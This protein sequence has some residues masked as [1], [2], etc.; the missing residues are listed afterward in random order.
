MS[1]ISEVVLNPETSQRISEH[2]KK[3]WKEPRI[4]PI[5]K[6]ADWYVQSGD[7][8]MPIRE[9][10]GIAGSYFGTGPATIPTIQAMCTVC[11]YVHTFLLMPIL[12][13]ESGNG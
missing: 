4:C 3:H 1:E 2:L 8:I 12:N 5:C 6:S 10:M 9:I 11:F 13:G 7:L